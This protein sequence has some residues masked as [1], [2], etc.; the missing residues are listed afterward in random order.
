M[1][2]RYYEDDKRINVELL[3]ESDRSLFQMIAKEISDK[4]NVKWKPKIDGLDQ[5]YWDFEFKGITLTLHLEHF[6]G[7][8][9]FADKTETNIEHAKPVLE[10]IGNHFKTRNPPL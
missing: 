6:L 1:N 10:E 2:V 7:I 5:R 8:S 3:R 4:F 9:V